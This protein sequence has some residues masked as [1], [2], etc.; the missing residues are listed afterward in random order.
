VSAGEYHSG[1]ASE[2]T[3]YG[4]GSN[5]YLCTGLGKNTSLQ[6]GAAR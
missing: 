5:N 6:V 1:A 3:V 4:W 2:T